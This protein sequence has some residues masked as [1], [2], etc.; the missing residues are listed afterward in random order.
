MQTDTPPRTIPISG[1]ISEEDYEFLMQY[2]I[3]GKVTASEK[4]RHLATFFRQYH[5]SMQSYGECLNE[6]Q[7]SMEPFTKSLKSLE[8][9]SNHH[10]ELLDRLLSF[11]AEM[12][13]NLITARIPSGTDEGISYLRSLEERLFRMTLQQLEG[14]LRMGLTRES[15]TFNPQLLHGKL[16]TV[17]ELVVIISSRAS[18][19]LSQKETL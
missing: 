18:N 8:N 5:E 19:N 15:P 10:S 16:S 3:S 7:R 17:K 13:A 1:R 14:I 4:L 12:S 9:E 2:R 6:L 11:S